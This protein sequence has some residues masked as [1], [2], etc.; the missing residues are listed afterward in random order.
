MHHGVSE[1]G[2]H[3]GSAACVAFWDRSLLRILGPQPLLRFGSA[4]YI[5]FLVHIPYC[6]LG[7]LWSSHSGI[8]GL[9]PMLSAAY[10]AI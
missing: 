9:P 3:L 10:L 8:L 4:S 1:D 7:P 2:T 5:E 6:I